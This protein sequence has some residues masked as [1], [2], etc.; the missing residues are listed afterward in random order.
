MYRS[1]VQEKAEPMAAQERLTRRQ[2]EILWLVLQEYIRTGHPVASRTLVE[3]YRLDYS[4]ATVRNEFAALTR[5]GYLS[6][7]HTS[8]G[9]VPTPKAYRFLVEHMDTWGGPPLHVQERVRRSLRPR[10]ASQEWL[11]RAAELLAEL[12]RA[13]AWVTAPRLEQATCQG[14]RLIPWNGRQ[15][16]L[17]VLLPGGWLRQRLIWLPRRVSREQVASWQ[18]YLN[19]RC[20]GRSLREL[21]ALPPPQDPILRRLWEDVLDEL[22]QAQRGGEPGVYHR[23]LQHVMRTEIAPQ[24]VRLLEEGRQ[25]RRMLARVAARLPVGEVRVLIGGTEGSPEELQGCAFIVSRYAARAPATGFL[26][27]VGP[28]RMPYNETVPTVRFLSRWLTQLFA[29]QPHPSE[30]TALRR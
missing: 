23:G 20:R 30:A 19:E 26:G 2:R 3:R 29:Q 28:L 13:A 9:R 12:A 5:A 17:L 15:A 14:V 7:P 27:V 1:L 25:L 18:R 8:A 22:D 11:V 24:A 16:L 6:Q 21:T 10:G 4:P